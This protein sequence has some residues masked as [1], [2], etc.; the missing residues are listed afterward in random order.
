MTKDQDLHYLLQ[1]HYLHTLVLDQS[2]DHCLPIIQDRI[3]EAY[4]HILELKGNKDRCLDKGGSQSNTTPLKQDH[5]EIVLC[6]D[7]DHFAYMLIQKVQSLYRLC[8]H[9]LLLPMTELNLPNQCLKLMLQSTDNCIRKRFMGFHTNQGKFSLN[10]MKT[11]MPQVRQ[12][13]ILNRK[14]REFSLKYMYK[15][16]EY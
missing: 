10:Q 11:L 13:A 1:G 2:R 5:C 12:P 7:R 4:I 9:Y 15:I 16:S 6:L 3:R 14:I 8:I